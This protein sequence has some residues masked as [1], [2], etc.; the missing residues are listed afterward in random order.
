[1]NIW[2]SVLKTGTVHVV[3]KAALCLC[4][5]VSSCRSLVILYMEVKF[6]VLSLSLFVF[7]GI[8]VCK[9]EGELLAVE[10]LHSSGNELFTGD[11]LGEKDCLAWTQRLQVLSQIF[12]RRYL[13][14]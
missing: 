1:M 4:S 2:I 10:L 3:G 8:P 9:S 13:H 12:R 5:Y 7:K 11:F 6:L 14:F